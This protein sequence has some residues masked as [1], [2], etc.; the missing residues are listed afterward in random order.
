[1]Q[2]LPCDGFVDGRQ[3]DSW[4]SRKVSVGSPS[5]SYIPLESL[6][7]RIRPRYPCSNGGTAFPRRQGLAKALCRI[8]RRTAAGDGPSGGAMSNRVPGTGCF[9]LPKPILAHHDWITCVSAGRAVRPSRIQRQPHRCHTRFVACQAWGSA[10]GPSAWW[11]TPGP[12]RSAAAPVGGL[13]RNGH[14]TGTAAACRRLQSSC[15]R[16]VHAVRAN[17]RSS[18][19][20]DDNKQI[21]ANC[22]Q[23]PIPTQSSAPAC[24]RIHREQEAGQWPSDKPPRSTREQPIRTHRAYSVGV[25]P[26]DGA[27]VSLGGEITISIRDL[28]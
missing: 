15:Q 20:S 21:P 27:K 17:G 13:S 18:Q 9:F 10:P 28:Q 22:C 2:A 5:E 6:L 25:Q 14:G 12:R 11:D 24:C 19:A 16:S 3:L 26:M 7:T 23:P 1:M 8:C 4:Q